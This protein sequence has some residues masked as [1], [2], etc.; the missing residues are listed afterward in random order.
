MIFNCLKFLFYQLDLSFQDLNFWPIYTTLAI[1]QKLTNNLFLGPTGTAG[2][3]NSSMS[4]IMGTPS[5]PS[6]IPMAQYQQMQQQ[7]Q[8]AEQT[9]LM[10]ADASRKISAGDVLDG[11]KSQPM[12]DMGKQRSL[13]TPNTPQQVE[14]FSHYQNADGTMMLNPMVGFKMYR[15]SLPY[16]TFGSGKKL[17]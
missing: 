11:R 3:A 12:A 7:Q 17:H 10:A 16:V 1:D 2:T 14:A 8:Q 4:T 9:L 6:M 15:G 5:L 13:S